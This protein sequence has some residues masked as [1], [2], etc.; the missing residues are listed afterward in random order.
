MTKADVR[1]MIQMSD[2]DLVYT[3]LLD[4]GQDDLADW[5]AEKYF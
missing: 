1:L 2:A 4:M 5:V 3:M